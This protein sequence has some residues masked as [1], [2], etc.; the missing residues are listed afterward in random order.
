MVFAS[1]F[2]GCIVHSQGLVTQIIYVKDLQQNPIPTASFNLQGSFLDARSNSAGMYRLLLPSNGNY[3]LE[4][5]APYYETIPLNVIISEASNSPL[6]VELSPSSF[7]E[8]TLLEDGTDALTLSESDLE[9][10]GGDAAAPY[11]LQATRDIFLGSA[12][13]DFGQAFFKIKSLDA[14]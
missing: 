7:R 9:G 1:L 14:K 4:I 11:L 8:N 13:F 3:T 12:A 10:L 5:S 2:M 6:Y